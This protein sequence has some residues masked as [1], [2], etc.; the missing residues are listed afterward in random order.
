MPA[1]RGIFAAS[2]SLLVA[3]AGIAAGASAGLAAAPAPWPVSS[4]LVVAE[5]VT[6]GAS[7]SDEYL[8]IYNAAPGPAEA[9]GCQLV[10]VSASGATV[11][12][13]ATLATPL[14]LAAGQHLLV[15]NASGIY[16]PLAD[17][18]YTGGLA[19]DGGSVVLETPG[20]TVIDAVNWGTASNPYAEGPAA[21][22][23]P[24]KSSIER[25][26]GGSLGNGLD[27]ND[28]RAD[29]AIQPNPQPQPMSAPPVPGPAPT[30]T[31]S[32]AS[33][34]PA[35]SPEVTPTSEPTDGPTL[36]PTAATTDSA[37]PTPTPTQTLAP[38]LVPTATATVAPTAEPT[39]WA[40]STPSAGPTSE[41]TAGATPTPSGSPAPSPAAP[42]ITPIAEAR[43]SADGATVT[44]EGVVTAAIGSLESG[45]GGF[46]QDSSGGVAVYLSDSP[47]APVTA[48]S[49][50]RVTGTIG[51]RYGQRTVR[52]EAAGAADP[53]GGSGSAGIVVLGQAA[54]P[55]A[56]A[57]TTGAI[58][59][60]DEGFLVSAVGTVT[61]AP[62]AL[63]DG[64]GL[65]L[66]DGSGPLRV[67]VTPAALGGLVPVRGT[68][69]AVTGPVGQHASGSSPGY[70]LEATEPGDAVVIVDSSPEPSTSPTSGPSPTASPSVMATPGPTASAAP[71]PGPSASDPGLDVVSM[72]VA[73]GLPAGSRVRVAGVV[74]AGSGVLGT[75]GLVALADSSGGVFVRLASPL[76]SFEPGRS[77]EIVGTI[78]APYG[79][80]EIRDLTWIAVGDLGE[81]PAPAAISLAQ[82]GEST[83]GSLVRVR[84]SVDSVR[85]DSGRLTLT[86]ES[87]TGTARVLADPPT[88]LTRADVTR[89]AIVEVTGIVGQRASASGALDGYRIWLRARA[90]LATVAAAPTA[91]LSAG[92]S[93]APTTTPHPDLASAISIRNARVD[94]RATVTAAA[95][96]LDIDGPTIVVDDGTAAVAVVLPDDAARPRV[97]TMVRVIGTVGTWHGGPKV[98]AT[99]VEQLGQLG[100]VTALSSNGRIGAAQE[101]HLIRVCG[102][103]DSLARAGSRWRAELI[104]DGRRVVVLAEP[105][106]GVPAALMVK[107]GL[108][109]VTGIVRRSSS[110]SSVFQVLP[111]DREDVR[112]AVPPSAAGAS[113]SFGAGSVAASGRPGSKQLTS[114]GDLGSW[115]GRDVVVAGL[116]TAADGSTVVLDDGTGSVVLGGSEAA[117][118]LAIVEPGDALEV[119]GEV[120]SGPGGLSLIVDPAGIVTLDGLAGDGAAAESPAGLGGDVSGAA[121]SPRGVG[122]TGAGTGP[123]AIGGSTSL[124]LGSPGSLDQSPWPL[125]AIGG[126]AVLLLLAAAG[127]TLAT[128]RSVASGQAAAARAA[129]IEHRRIPGRAVA[130]V[131]GLRSRSP[132]EAP[133]PGPGDSEWP[134]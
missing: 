48:G 101:W 10:Y 134:G 8:E 66:D 92:P 43:A 1:P 46:V 36:A 51:D 27:T 108:A 35:I 124:H 15:A 19:A 127:R 116:V 96:L 118:A 93:A 18:T 106:A 17:A 39:A 107:G 47:S 55:P 87:G 71:T 72:A 129:G 49:L 42:T 130:F 3:M 12:R 78:A 82:L 7:A 98:V 120:R 128:R 126:T 28:N 104:V 23:P 56:A 112:V 133:A 121:G 70:R 33:T 31:S 79:Q 29:W 63:S 114:I 88:G 45:H 75:D 115:V 80:V 110:D 62:D 81:P 111:R 97:G 59:E 90:D 123:G 38:T 26:P 61:A 102:R 25:L 57:R 13:K 32:P 105:A 60:D 89:G 125:L 6:G 86:I 95:G 53:S 74:T 34:G 11:T 73:R 58:G 68:R 4:G 64:T 94:V 37:A 9:G 41:P 100:S 30:T 132:S 67:V 21:P 91:G 52:V 14:V 117:E 5:V 50:V 109:A 84:G 122:L 40:T 83:E 119:S 24:A 65:W 54:L 20:G 99:S 113:S 69:I 103:I 44:V 85:L 22:A 77:V 76:D 131:R 16:A 2:A